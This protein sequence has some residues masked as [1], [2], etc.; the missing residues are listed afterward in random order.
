MSA[1][2]Q[3]LAVFGRALASPR[4][5]VVFFLFMA[6]AALGVVYEV[7]AP[8]PAVLGP[9]SLLVVNLTASIASKARFRAD[10]PLLVF[11]V[12][13]LALVALLAVARL[14][15]F[16]GSAKVPTG[17]WF[18]GEL[19]TSEQGALHGAGARALRFSNQGFT[20]VFPG[21]NKYRT[22]QNRVHFKDAAGNTHEGVIGD[23]HPLVMNG[24]RI[25]TSRNRGFVPMLQWSADNGAI[26]FAAMQLGEI[27]IDGFTYGMEWK[28]PS[29]P[30]VW[31]SL[32]TETMQSARGAP[33]ENLGAKQA[34][35]KVVLFLDQR[36]YELQ[37]GETVKLPGGQLTYTGLSAW[38]GY[39]IIYDETQPWLIG[40]IS[41]AIASLLW[42]YARRLWRTWDDDSMSEEDDDVTFK[43]N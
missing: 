5:M 12:A 16:E 18:S 39:N 6:A 24:Y 42:F 25:Y 14:T 26:Q 34:P 4:L 31:L 17:A 10:L 11:H 37:I 19:F 27:G 38:M 36:F 41:I 32:S 22:T 20:E 40:T 35:N 7:V 15:Y 3:R 29:G 30:E 8:T 1:M 28:I 13:L 2:G 23:D 43:A 21:Q 9:L 33:R